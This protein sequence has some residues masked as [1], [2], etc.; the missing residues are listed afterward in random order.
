MLKNT[1]LSGLMLCTFL[2]SAQPKAFPT[3]GGFGAYAT[4]GRGGEVFVVSNLNDHGPG[5]LREAIEAKGPRIVVFKVAGTIELKKELRITESDLTIAG[6]S[7]PG[8]GITLKNFPLFVDGANNVI[9]RAIRVRP[10]TRSG[11]I[12]SEIDALQIRNS[13]QVIIDHCTFSWSVDEMMNTWHGTEDLTIQWCIAAESLTKSIHEKG[14]HGYGASLGGKRTSYHHNLFAHHTARNPSVAGNADENTI[15]MDFRNNVIYNWGH[16]TC[17]G[18]PLSINFVDN[19]YKPGPATSDKVKKRLVRVE[20]ADQYG[21]RP[22]WYIAGNYMEGFPEAEQDNWKYAVEHSS[23]VLESDF[24]V[25]QPF[26]TAPVATQPATEAYKSVLKNAGLIAPAR[27]SWE[28]RILKEVKKGKV[29]N[30][31]GHINTIEDA[32]GWPILKTGKA[33]RDSDNDGM[34]DR[35]EQKNGLNPNDPSDTKGDRNGD[36][37]SNI[38]NYLNSI[39]P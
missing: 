29:Q 9:V 1:F 12:G 5:S 39:L 8:E 2:V 22:Q 15:L 6:Q 33:P 26:D 7:A 19:Y 11:L 30:N 10:G 3:A 35:W 24:R 38:E 20:S 28:K 16:R 27:D 18:K 32:G 37:Y 36:G 21:F 4:G 34:P 31:Q 17:D 14:A 13:K 25:D 23:D